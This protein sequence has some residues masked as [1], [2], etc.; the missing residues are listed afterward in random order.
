MFEELERK[1]KRLEELEKLLSRP[2]IVAK[3]ELYQIYAK[4]HSELSRLV[5]KY[6][7]HKRIEKEIADIESVLTLRHD[8]DFVELAESELS[9]LQSQLEDN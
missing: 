9:E 3:S 4:E 1:E 6:R 7:E 2:E 8:P 5:T